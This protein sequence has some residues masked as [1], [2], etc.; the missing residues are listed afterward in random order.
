M[1]DRHTTGVTLS[2]FRIRNMRGG[3]GFQEKR[4]VLEVSKICGV[5]FRK[6]HI[7]S[8]KNDHEI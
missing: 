1:N 2:F 8:L 6:I 5:C 3:N 7:V 4:Q